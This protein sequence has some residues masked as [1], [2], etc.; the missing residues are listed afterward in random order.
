MRYPFG[1]AHSVGAILLLKG[2][3]KSNIQG[4]L[5]GVSIGHHRHILL[6]KAIVKAKGSKVVLQG[7]VGSIKLHIGNILAIVVKVSLHMAVVAAAS[8]LHAHNKF[9]VHLAPCVGYVVG[10]LV[11][12]CHTL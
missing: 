1:A 9:S 11:K 6:A 2:L 7:I 4:A 12:V 8:L 5:V 10:K 3:V